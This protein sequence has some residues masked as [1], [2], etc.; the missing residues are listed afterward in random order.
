MI[1]VYH[2][3]KHC[4]LQNSQI[5]WEAFI[6]FLRLWSP[7]IHIITL[8]F[9]QQTRFKSTFPTRVPLYGFLFHGRLGP[10]IKFH[11][12]HARVGVWESPFPSFLLWHIP[13]HCWT[14]TAQRLQTA[15]VSPH[16]TFIVPD[17]AHKGVHRC[18]RRWLVSLSSQRDLWGLKDATRQGSS[19]D[20]LGFLAGP[21]GSGEGS[22]H[23]G[24]CLSC[25]H[26]LSSLGLRRLSKDLCRLGF[27]VVP[28]FT[29]SFQGGSWKGYAVGLSQIQAKYELED[30]KK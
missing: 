14:W 22:H 10:F 8:W 27:W 4:E 7:Q 30:L 9:D 16:D 21:W 28:R 19:H 2:M 25:Y 15:F 29:S 6:E 20:S 12:C 23:G 17:S 26:S 3:N 13:D 1:T 18:L 11:Y 24:S 5:K